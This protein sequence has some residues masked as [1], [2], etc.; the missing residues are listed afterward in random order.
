[1]LYLFIIKKNNQFGL[2][3]KNNNKKNNK[4]KFINLKYNCN[5]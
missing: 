4:K 2:K 3:T 5:Y 1:M